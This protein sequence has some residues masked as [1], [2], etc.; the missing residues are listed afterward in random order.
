MFKRNRAWISCSSLLWWNFDLLIFALFVSH[1]LTV[2]NVARRIIDWWQSI[3]GSYRLTA[4]GNLA[5][6][7]WTFFCDFCDFAFF[8]HFGRLCIDDFHKFYYI[9]CYRKLYDSLATSCLGWTVS[10]ILDLGDCTCL[11]FLRGSIYF[12]LSVLVESILIFGVD[13]TDIGENDRLEYH[14]I[15]HPKKDHCKPCFKEDT[16][17]V[18][19][20][21]AQHWDC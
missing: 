5:Y 9:D 12:V 17:Y 15:E 7:F 21:K 6:R 2:R 14:S 18:H 16:E 13:W 8:L 4:S 19:S 11:D 10:F 20:S 1:S 3:G